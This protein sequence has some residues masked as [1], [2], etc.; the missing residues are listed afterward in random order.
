MSKETSS[1]NQVRKW[2]KLSKNTYRGR[3]APSPTGDLHLGSLTAAIISYLQARVNNGLWLLRIED[4]DE[5]RNIAGADLQIIKTLNRFGL[6]SD[7]DVLY[8]TSEQRQV[9]YQNAY[10]FLES[11]KL[12]YRCICTRKQL[13]GLST[14]P[15][16]CRNQSHPIDSLH[17]TRVKTTHQFFEFEDLFQGHQ[18]QNIAEQSGD[19]NIKRKDGLF[20]YQL[21]VVIDDADQGIT[22]VVRGTDIMDSTSRQMYLIKQLNLAQPKYAHFP[23]L[24]NLEGMKLSKQNHSK[25]ITHEDPY[26]TTRLVLKL[27]GQHPPNLKQKTQ[28]ALL[29]WAIENWQPEKLFKQAKITNCHQSP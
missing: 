4:I 10:Q 19:F 11:N 8:Q 1:Q 12:T 16:T 15:N 21:A 24:V 6:H 13:A 22:E 29:N 5:T 20:C 14:Y 9:A 18:V 3:F 17:S 28:S 7:E 26:E 25:A 2:S 23:I 27:L